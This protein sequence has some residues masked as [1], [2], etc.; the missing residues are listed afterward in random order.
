[1][2]LQKK[3]IKLKIEECLKLKQS[4]DVWKLLKVISGNDNK[5]N[6]EELLLH[7]TAADEL[8]KFYSR[9]EKNTTEMNQTNTP[10]NESVLD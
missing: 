2:H 6:V 9:F 8:N 7:Q 4:K 1:M 10:F 3:K 5:R